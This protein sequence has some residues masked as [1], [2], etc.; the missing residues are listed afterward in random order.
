MSAA[1]IIKVF[2]DR[3]P[4]LGPAV[5]MLTVEYLV[6]QVIV[7]SV[8]H[9]PGYSW[10]LNTISD[11][12]NTVCGLYSGRFVCSPLHVFMNTSFV[13]LGLLMA[14][15]SLLIYQEFRENW[16]TLLGFI[17]MGVAGLGTVA[18]GLAPENVNRV[19][20]FTGALMPLLLGNVSMIVLSL[21]L[22]RVPRWMRLYT[23]LSGAIAVVA[24]VFFILHAY[25]PFGIGG[26]ERLAAYPQTV[27]LILFGW[28]MTHNHIR[29]LKALRV[30]GTLD[31]RS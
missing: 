20:H 19:A 15:G 11:L 3:Y 10:R 28:Y 9:N 18:V 8:W 4:L 1:R 29:R 16:V 17:L 5:W 21:A 14:S 12:G 7:A 27:W 13:A 30:N 23:F 24:L 25:G 31:S 26:M 2:T 22:V 6:T